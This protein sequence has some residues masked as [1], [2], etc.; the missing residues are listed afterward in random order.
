MKRTCSA[1]IYVHSAPKKAKPPFPSGL[2]KDWK[3]KAK[4][5]APSRE[6]QAARSPK[7]DDDLGTGGLH[8]EDAF[9]DPPVS[10]AKSRDK[11]RSNTVNLYSPKINS[12]PI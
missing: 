1:D 3:V 2:V 12:H 5:I 10:S 4:S 9:A 11:N 6:I 7:S 8:D